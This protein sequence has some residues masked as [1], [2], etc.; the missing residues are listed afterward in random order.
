MQ[1]ESTQRERANETY[2]ARRSARD[3]KF[4]KMIDE[5]MVR[6]PEVGEHPRHVSAL[7]TARKLADE[8]ARNAPLRRWVIPSGHA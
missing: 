1:A 8:G 6:L 5:V 3:A 7:N 2:I 4:Q